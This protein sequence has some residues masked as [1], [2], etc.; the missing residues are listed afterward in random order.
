MRDRL[1]PLEAPAGSAVIM[2]GR[3]LHTNGV[4]TNGRTRAGI[5]SWYTLPVYLP[6]ENW[7]LSLNPSVR[8]VGSETLQTLLGFRPQVLGRVNGRDRI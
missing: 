1:V 8:Q 3:L 4:N 2:E 7:Y 6:Q 5:F